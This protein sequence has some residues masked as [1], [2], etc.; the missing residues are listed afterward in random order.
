[1][2]VRS[3]LLL[4]AIAF[5]STGRAEAAFSTFPVSVF[6][7]GGTGSANLVGNTAATARLNRN[8]TIGLNYGGDINPVLGSRLFFNITA[9]SNN[10]TYVWVRLGNWNGST[11]T[12]AAAAGQTAPNGAATTNI[13]AQ[14]TGAG[15][16]IIF[17]DPFYASCQSIGGCN[18][19][20]FG[21]STFSAVGSFYR[22][23]TLVAATPEPTTWAMMMLGFAG[24]ALRMKS[25]RRRI[26]AAA[27]IRPPSAA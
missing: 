3:L 27:S 1:M 6:Q 8:Q 7:T 10:T 2:L 20:V 16:I 26:S 25:A 12:N 15:V 18:A 22:I 4:I 5:A 14:A 9:V 21:N 11:F 17:L 13:Y 24:V 19:L 23:S